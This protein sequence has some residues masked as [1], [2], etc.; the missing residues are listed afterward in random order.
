MSANGV[1]RRR[2]KEM[3]GTEEEERDGWNGGGRKRWMEWRRKKEM[4]GMEEEERDGWNGG[5]RKRWMEWR[6]REM[7]G[8]EVEVVE[9]SEMI[10]NRLRWVNGGEQTTGWIEG[11]DE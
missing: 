5:G 4:D 6:R 9:K 2:K 1:E 7:D 11:D 10:E 3:D 8:M